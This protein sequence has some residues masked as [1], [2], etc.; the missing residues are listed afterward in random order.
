M[1]PRKFLT[2]AEASAYINSRGIPMKEMGLSTLACRRG[3]PS[4]S[5][6]HGRAVYT[7]EAIDEWIDREFERNFR[8][9]AS[10]S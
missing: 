7:I 10:N 2:R 9:P 8:Q 6:V 3:G 4:Y 1:E 5:I